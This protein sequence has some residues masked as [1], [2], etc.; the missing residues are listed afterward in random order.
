[1]YIYHHS[2]YLLRN[3][4]KNYHYIYGFRNNVCKN[5]RIKKRW[6]LIKVRIPEETVWCQPLGKRPEAFQYDS[7][8]LTNGA[9]GV[10]LVRK[11]CEMTTCSLVFYQRVFH[12]PPTSRT[13]FPERSNKKTSEFPPSIDTLLRTKDAHFNVAPLT[14]DPRLEACGSSFMGLPCD[15]WG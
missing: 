5:I 7:I 8:K 12:S 2:T 1:M 4:T 3:Q 6:F 11:L 15:L 10:F 9:S 14:V 13:E